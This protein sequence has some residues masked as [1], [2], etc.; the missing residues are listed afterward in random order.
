MTHAQFKAAFSCRI[1][2]GDPVST[3]PNSGDTAPCVI[4]GYEP[5]PRCPDV[6]VWA[7]T[8]CGRIPGFRH[9]WTRGQAIEQFGRQA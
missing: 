7:L 3:G 5:D 9:G 1:Y 2:H 4:I 6:V 8:R